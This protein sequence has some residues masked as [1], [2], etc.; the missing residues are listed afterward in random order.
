[1]RSIRPMPDSRGLAL[2]CVA[3]ATWSLAAIPTGCHRSPTPPIGAAHGPDASPVRG[4]T[5]RLASFKDIRNLDPAGPG[6][7]LSLPIQHQIFAGLVDL[8]ARGRVVADLAERWEIVDEGRTVR[9]FLRPGVVMQD[10]RELDATDIKRSAERALHPSAPNPTASYYEGIDGYRDFVSGAADHIAGIVVEGRTVLSFR[11]EH[12]DATFLP[13]LGM[14]ALRPVC[15]TAGERYDD[16]WS[17]CGAGPFRLER[18][19]WQPA[20][21][22]R[23]V[24]HE[25]YFRP[26]LPYLDAIEWTFN[27]DPLA[28]RFRFESGDLDVVSDLA[29]ADQARFNGDPLWRPFGSSEGDTRLYGEAMN[30]RMP[31]FDNVEVRR[32]VAAAIDRDHYRLLRPGR[33][34]ALTQPI[35]PGIDGYD[36]SLD[37]QRYDQAAALDHMRRAG[38][39][40]EPSTGAGGWPKPI[41]YPLYDQ[42]LLMFTAQLLQQDLAKIGLRIELRLMSWQAFL[43]LQM[44][45]D[46]A[47]L[48][49]GNWEMD[50]PDA[51]S[52]LEPLFTTNALPPAGD[53]IAF[54]SNPVVDD[55][56]ARARQEM[57]PDRRRRL[58]RHASRILCEDAPWAFAYSYHFF[59]LHQPY[60]R[61]Y[62]PHAVFHLDATQ[63]WVDRKPAEIRSSPLGRSF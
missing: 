63:V 5:L 33:M 23:L 29:E 15:R 46:G 49:Q 10:G 53:N 27:M 37:G 18:G 8:D 35:P 34:T 56:T 47:A 14:M 25:A 6:D 44:R 39:P 45:P 55:L 9:F 62:A 28:Q 4:G 36:S 30:T 32:A 7:G 48:S 54:Y 42:G 61:G 12:P 1:M 13:L 17:P 52:F 20:I 2:A 22:V 21:G 40:Y 60:V 51:S 3:V 24:R 41:A 19:G 31:P 16:T 38:Y 11:L 58:Y 59:Y 26:G 43:A 57:D 50:Y